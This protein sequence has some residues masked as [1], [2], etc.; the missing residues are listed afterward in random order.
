VQSAELVEIMGP[1]LAIGL[2]VAIVHAPI[3][4]EVL[5]RGIVFIDLAIAQIASLYVVLVKLWWHEPSWLMIQ[6]AAVFSAV[7]A[8]VL[9][10]WVEQKLPREQ[11]AIIGSTYI[12]AASAALLAVANH[13]RGG[14][15]IQHILAGQ[16]LFAS[17]SDVVVFAPV[18]T[19][20]TA[21]WF[22]CPRARRGLPFFLVFALV[23]TASV[24]LVGVYVVFASL[25][26]PALAV[27]RLGCHKAAVAIGM[28]VLAVFAGIAASTLRDLPAGPVLVFAFAFA[29]LGCRLACSIYGRD[30]TAASG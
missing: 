15:E 10:R 18:Y 27:N 2:M 30:K 5:A 17:W 8:A 13:P 4:I 29:A 20:G 11:E 7:I 12:L 1:A 3:G 26:L 25:I 22:G 28:A 9:F 6:G 16:I 14:E 24:Q 21:L 19:I 23:V